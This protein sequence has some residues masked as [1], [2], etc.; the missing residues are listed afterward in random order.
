MGGADEHGRAG[1]FAALAPAIIVVLLL[2]G[3]AGGA[4]VTAQ[5][6][7]AAA[8][9]LAPAQAPAASPAPVVAAPPAAKVADDQRVRCE[10]QIVTGSRVP[11]RVCR[12]EAQWRLLEQQ[13]KERGRE[14]QGPIYGPKEVAAA[15]TPPL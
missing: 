5:M 2:A 1:A 3:C 8:P 14:L 6:S 11:Q 9:T 10:D 12:T 7:Q 4:P 15:G 13:S